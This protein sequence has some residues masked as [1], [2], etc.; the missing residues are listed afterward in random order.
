MNNTILNI[1]SITFKEVFTLTLLRILVYTYETNR[2]IKREL[3]EIEMDI[4]YNYNSKITITEF[5]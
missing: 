5:C 1:L 3:G 2:N 4:K